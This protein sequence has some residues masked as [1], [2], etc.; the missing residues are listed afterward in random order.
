[1]LLPI[2]TDLTFIG[3]Y[4][5]NIDRLPKIQGLGDIFIITRSYTSFTSACAIRLT[6]QKISILQSHT[7]PVYD[8]TGN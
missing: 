3:L 1:M 5:E 8:T 6:S 7:T 2:T 4:H